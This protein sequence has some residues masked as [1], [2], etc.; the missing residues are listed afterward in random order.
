MAVL[1]IIPG[2]GTALVWV[3]AAGWLYLSDEVAAAAG[4]TVWCIAVVGMVDNIIRP[5][6]VGRDTQM[7]DLMIMLSTL[8][9]LLL[10]GAPGLIVGPI[11]AGIFVTVWEI[12]GETFAAF[13]PDVDFH[14]A[15]SES[16]NGDSETE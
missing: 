6:V 4:L 15:P 2:L 12:Y 14:P 8:G 10:F 9:G 1:S 3:P 13:L 16:A 7:S 5:W 11:L